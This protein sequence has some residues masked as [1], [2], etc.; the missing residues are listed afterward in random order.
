MAI[1]VTLTD[2]AEAAAALTQ[3]Q[4]DTNLQAVEAAFATAAADAITISAGTGLSGGGS[5]AANRTL[6]LA[7]TA[8]TPGT[9]T[10]PTVTVDAQGRLTAASSNTPPE[11]GI[12]A[13]GGEGQ[14]LRKLSGTDF[15]A[16]WVD[17]TSSQ[18]QEPGQSLVTGATYA[19]TV[20]DGSDNNIVLV[21]TDDDQVISIPGT[22]TPGTVYVVRC[23]HEGVTVVSPA[24]TITPNPAYLAPDDISMIEVIENAGTAPDVAVSGGVIVPPTSVGAI[25]TYTVADHGVVF[26]LTGNHTQNFTDAADYP[27]GFSCRF[28]KTATGD[29]PIAGTDASY[30]MPGPGWCHV[31]KLDTILMA[32]GNDATDPVLL[33]E[34]NAVPFDT[35]FVLC[36]T[37]ANVNDGGATAWTSPTNIQADDGSNASNNPFTVGAITQKLVASNFG[38]TIPT[39]ATITE[40]TV[41][42]QVFI[43]TAGADT[44][45]E[46][47]LQLSKNTGVTGY[48]TNLASGTPWTGAATNRDFVFTNLGDMPTEA[49]AEDAGFSVILKVIKSGATSANNNVRV[50]AVWIRIQGL[51]P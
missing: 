25:R 26:L 15:D 47:T 43:Q 12:P 37:G 49:E 23:R 9:Y 19:T 33:S 32:H 7:N 8:V 22:T 27:N 45:T 41:R 38:F 51:E 11:A 48:S 24:G 2:R 5:L 39:G 42:L 18:D 28:R 46:H 1:T 6:A 34:G 3:S 21:T 36:G 17:E 29:S 35:G 13:G 40:V 4:H 20:A 30:A 10:Y 31:E 44:F 50:D 16:D 14:V